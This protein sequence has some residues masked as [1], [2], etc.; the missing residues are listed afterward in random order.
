M[1]VQPK[2]VY[3]IPDKPGRLRLVEGPWM[4][5]KLKPVRDGKYLR[6]WLASDD[7]AFSW[8]RRGTW[9][10]SE[11]FDSKSDHQDIP[12][13]GGVRA[14]ERDEAAGAWAY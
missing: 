4:D 14:K 5:G 8:Y 6:H 9:F 3:P 13:A 11:F 12:W 10:A 2:D 1:Q 7:K